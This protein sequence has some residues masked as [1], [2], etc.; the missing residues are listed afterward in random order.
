MQTFNPLTITFY[1]FLND[2]LKWEKSI[3]YKVTERQQDE[4][5]YNY[6]AHDGER[7]A[8]HETDDA[9][10]KLKLSNEFFKIAPEQAEDWMTTVVNNDSF[11]GNDDRVSL[12][13][14]IAIE[15]LNSEKTDLRKLTI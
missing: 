15:K 13:Y 11:E 1:Y 12:L 9:E 10:Y 5:L 7:F 2:Q 14:S 6:A 3:K 4:T 8:I